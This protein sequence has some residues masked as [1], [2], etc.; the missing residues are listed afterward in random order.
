MTDLTP[1]SNQR[2]VL[3]RC[4][5]E[6]GRC[7]RCGSCRTVCPSFLQKNEESFSPRGRVALARAVLEGRLSVSTVFEDRLGSCTGCLACESACAG[8]VPVYEIVQ[9]AKEQAVAEVGT[10]IIRSLLARVLKNERMMRA[11]AWLAPLALHYRFQMRSTERAARNASAI[12]GGP[13][14]GK[15]VFFPGCAVNHFQPE[16]G[17]AAINVLHAIGY[18]VIVPD[19]LKCCGRPLLSLGDREAAR[20]Q[21]EH[22]QALF[23]G[24]RAD[25]VVTACASC[26]L[27]FKKEYPTLLRPGGK[28]V[29]VLDIHE[30]LA[31]RLQEADLSHVDA[32]ITWHDP[33]HLGRGQGLAKTARQLLTAIP[34]VTLIEMKDADRCCGFGG[35]MRVTHTQLSD[36]IADVK[37]R[38]IVATRARTVVT[39][40]PGCGMQIR[41][42]LARAGSDIQVLHTVQLLEKALSNATRDKSD[43]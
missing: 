5:R 32:R 30:F 14:K 1:S 8:A 24:I 43:K 2:S 6:I 3:E 37:A 22:N 17:A 20:E 36:G 39:G 19:G 23:A 18:D 38:N 31:E 12:K 28:T 4:R 21:A 41:E 10:G 15:V 11:T 35:I 13:S 34:G 42:G 9:A 7:V 40:C 25:A 26:S 27:T 33:C 16:V 29:S